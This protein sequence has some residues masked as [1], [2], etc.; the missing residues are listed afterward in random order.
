MKE[1][2]DLKVPDLV[3]ISESKIFQSDI[4]ALLQPIIH[5][6]DYFLNS[7]D[8]HCYEDTYNQSFSYGGTLILWKRKLS[9]FVSVFPVKTSAFLPIIL[10]LPGAAISAHIAL[11][12][13]TRGRYSKFFDKVATLRL[14][15]SDIQ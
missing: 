15:L 5:E 7:E 12:L 11:Y 6:Y 8:L 14:C 3:F 10:K 9:S 1:F 2:L 13:P 4:Q